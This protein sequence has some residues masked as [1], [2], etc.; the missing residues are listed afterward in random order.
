M[1]TANLEYTLINLPTNSSGHQN[2]V[3][4]VYVGTSNIYALQQFGNDSV[5]SRAALTGTTIDFSAAGNDKMTLKN[6]GHA[7]TLDWY[8]YNGNDYFLVAIDPKANEPGSDKE[9]ATQLGRIQY[10][11][12]TI[13][14]Y[15]DIERFAEVNYN[16]YSGSSIGTTLRVEGAISTSR[17]YMLMTTI[18]I[19]DHHARLTYY[20]LQKANKA[21]D[22]QIALG[23]NYVS[24]T[25]SEMKAAAGSDSHSWETTKSL[26]GMTP[27]DSVQGID[28]SDGEA[29]YVSSGNVN[30]TPAIDKSSW[31]GTFTPVTFPKSQFPSSYVE[32]E[33][34]QIKD[35][36]YL[37]ISTHLNDSSDT[38]NYTTGNYVYSVS[39]DN[40]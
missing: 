4:K 18:R 5:I 25:N 11:A 9:W 3:Q 36:L 27:N 21:L 39:K 38:D 14:D 16:N 23:K 6:T 37:G 33:G 13:E 30:E 17:E 29:I 24:C 12:T 8:S 19:S 40:W 35:V 10:S 22:D 26:Y 32:T 1:A 20:D 2:V 15:T 28:L 7:Q 34:V 31:N